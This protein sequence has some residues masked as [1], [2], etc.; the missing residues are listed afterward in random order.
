M[1]GFKKVLTGILAATM[2]FGASMNVAA[3]S[4]NDENTSANSETVSI[5]IDQSTDADGTTNVTHTYYQI[6][7]ATYSGSNYAY[8]IPAANS[9][10]KD[11]VD[12]I[13]IEKN[14]ET[15]DVFGFVQSSDGSRY[16]VT[17]NDK[18]AESDGPAIATALNVPAVTNNAIASDSFG[19]TV[20]LSKGYY[21][22][23]SSLGSGL[24]LQTIEDQHIT[25]KNSYITTEKT[26]SLTN[27]SIGQ[28]VTYTIK[29]KVPAS[30]TVGD[31]ITVHDTLDTV[32]LQMQNDLQAKV[33]DAIVTLND[34]VKKADTE[35]FAKKFTVTE[36]GYL[37][38]GSYKPA[39]SL[40]AGEVGV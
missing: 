3:T 20:Q 28:A 12:A 37:E 31:E 38:P 7:A 23:T 24:V 22:I 25:E 16:N 2:I 1:K 32:H 21:L 33:G 8:Y 27:M 6:F 40:E 11:A 4:G 10:L 17:L 14:G 39:D 34:G 19:D 9:A 18:I 30:A 5:T 13:T 36:L 26:A 29:V 15:I 35:T